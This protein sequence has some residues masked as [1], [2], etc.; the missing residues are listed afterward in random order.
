MRIAADAELP[1]KKL[2]GLVGHS[3][4]VVDLGQPCRHSISDSLIRIDSLGVIAAAS[5]LDCLIAAPAIAGLQYRVR[6]RLEAAQART[7][8]SQ[9]VVFREGRG[10]LPSPK[11]RNR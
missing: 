8:N 9:K 11:F 7:G 10:R 2:V 6:K 3:A 4:S 5:F 1:I